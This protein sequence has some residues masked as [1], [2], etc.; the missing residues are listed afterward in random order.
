MEEKQQ[1]KSN[2]YLKHILIINFNG[3]FCFP[4]V[5]L[6]FIIIDIKYL[7]QF[8]LFLIDLLINN[9]SYRL[10]IHMAMQTDNATHTYLSF[11]MPL[12][13]YLYIYVLLLNII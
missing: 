1:K 2:K 12:H 3:F 6:L 8:F 9:I 5:R 13:I 11:K 10:C 7:L 4:L